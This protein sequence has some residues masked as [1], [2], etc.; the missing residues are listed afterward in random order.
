VSLSFRDLKPGGLYVTATPNELWVTAAVRPR[1]PEGTRLLVIEPVPSGW[2]TGPVCRVYRV[3]IDGTVGTLLV[4]EGDVLP[5][6]E[7]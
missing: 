3:L 2:D 4:G 7:A 6:E 1:I 5:M